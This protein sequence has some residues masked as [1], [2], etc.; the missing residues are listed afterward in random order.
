MRHYN[1][2]VIGFGRAESFVLGAG[3]KIV[4]VDEA[5][6]NK[7][8]PVAFFGVGHAKLHNIIVSNKLDF[9]FLDTGYLGNVKTKLYKRITKNKLNNTQNI[10]ERPSDRLEKLSIDRTSY[11]RGNKILIIPPDQK[12]LNCFE[13]TLNTSSWIQQTIESIKHHT[14]REIVVRERNRNRTERMI[15]DKFSDALQDNVHACVVWSSNCAV[16]SVLHN[17]P[18]ISL[19]PTATTKVSPFELNQIDNVPNLNQDLVENWLRHLSYCQ[20]TDSEMLSGFAWNLI[21]R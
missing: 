8:I 13:N 18:V 17:I 20:F 7:E 10:I 19:G 2:T 1:P 16:E 15:H 21:N 6:A 5:F 12:V 9:Y 4:S 14:D 11:S 3:G